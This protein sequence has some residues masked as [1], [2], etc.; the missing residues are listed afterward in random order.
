M[1]AFGTDV[2]SEITGTKRC[3][4]TKNKLDRNSRLFL[5]SRISQK[6]FGNFF[7]EF[8]CLNICG[9]ARTIDLRPDNGF[10]LE[11]FL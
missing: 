2:F 1:L 6:I 5:Q 11:D 9:L 10:S 8:A 4:P 7:D 3:V